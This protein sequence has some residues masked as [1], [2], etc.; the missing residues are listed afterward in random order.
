MIQ[1]EECIEIRHRSRFGKPEEPHDIV[2]KIRQILNWAFI[3]LGIVGA[4]MYAYG[5]WYRSNTKMEWMGTLV[6]IIAVV[7]KMS[8]CMLRLKK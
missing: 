6:V 3:V 5:V 8:E 1:E 7:V 2:F 4:A